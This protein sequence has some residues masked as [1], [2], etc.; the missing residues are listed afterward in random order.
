MERKSYSGLFSTITNYNGLATCVVAH[1]YICNI[2]SRID[3]YEYG[4]IGYDGEI[5]ACRPGTAGSRPQEL[6]A[7]SQ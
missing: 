2:N 3:A 6:V 4:P 1:H 5:Y 7:S